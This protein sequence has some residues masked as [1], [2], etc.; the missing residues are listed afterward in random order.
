[1]E[2]KHAAPN[3]WTFGIPPIKRLLAEEVTGGIWCDPFAGMKSPAQVKND[4][5]PEANAEFHMD[6]LEF[7]RAQPTG[8]FDGVLY[9]PPFSSRQASECYRSFGKELLTA[10]VTNNRYWADCKNEIARILKLG[11][12]ALCFGWNS[13]GVSMSRG[14]EMQRV[15]M[16]P[17]GGTRHDTICTVEIKTQC[18]LFNHAAIKEKPA[19]LE[20]PAEV[21]VRGQLADGLE[22][23]AV[24]RIDPADLPVAA[25]DSQ[26]LRARIP[27]TM[28]ET[29]H[30]P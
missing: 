29:N 23:F 10:T 21:G 13:M 1:M 12:K 9:D 18:V 27:S 16:V 6:A 20:T 11:G 30:E 28:T 15:L 19:R 14:F 2:R 22:G 17:H 25:K 24:R 7:L 26:S 4:L 5:N 8:H 3:K